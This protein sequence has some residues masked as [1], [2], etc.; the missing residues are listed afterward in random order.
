MPDINNPEINAINETSQEKT[1]PEAKKKPKA[2]RSK[3]I[4]DRKKVKELILDKG[5]SCREAGQII[6][7]SGQRINKLVNE[8]KANPALTL[9][10]ENKD[11]VF[12][13]I[14]ARLVNLVDDE[15]LK[16]WLERRGSTDL[17][18]LQDKIQALRGQPQGLTGV[19]IRI[20]LDNLPQA[21]IDVTPQDTTYS[22][23]PVMALL[24][25]T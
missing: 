16:K 13:D 1:E 15:I 5:L 18:I 7:V 2:T 11:K 9:F 6:G 22:G 21:P 23:E 3:P 4:V 24:D 10:S 14:Q 19:E 25:E 8:I 17:A 12:E 20:I